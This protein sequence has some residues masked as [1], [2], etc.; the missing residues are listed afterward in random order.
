MKNQNFLEILSFL[1]CEKK[2]LPEQTE[3]GVKAFKEFADNLGNQVVKVGRFNG[4][5][6]L[7]ISDK[8]SV[9][10]A[11]NGTSTEIA[12]LLGI[13]LRERPDVLMKLVG[14]INGC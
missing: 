9:M 14:I 5:S 1:R 7:L 10:S 13:F 11:G 12:T 3:N 6:L 2:L 8:K 4:S